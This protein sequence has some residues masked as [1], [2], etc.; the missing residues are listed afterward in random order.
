MTRPN[1]PTEQQLFAKWERDLI[2]PT[3]LDDS[4]YI[5]DPLVD[6]TVEQ[7]KTNQILR[8]IVDSNFGF[9]PYSDI[10][11]R[12]VIEADTYSA[13]GLNM[14]NELHKDELCCQLSDI[15]LFV[16]NNRIEHIIPSNLK[17]H[18]SEIVWAGDIIETI[19][20]LYD[21]ATSEE[22]F[23]DLLKDI[24]LGTASEV[25]KIVKDHFFEKT[26]AI[27]ERAR[28]AKINSTVSQK[29]DTFFEHMNS[30]AV[31][32]L[33]SMSISKNCTYENG[34]EESIELA[35]G[36]VKDGEEYVNSHNYRLTIEKCI[37]NVLSDDLPQHIIN[38]LRAQN[39]NLTFDGTSALLDIRYVRQIEVG[40]ADEASFRDFIEIESGSQYLTIHNDLSMK[41]TLGYPPDGK[42]YD[43]ARQIISS[44]FNVMELSEHEDAM[45]KMDSPLED[46]FID[47]Y[48]MSCE[49]SLPEGIRRMR[50]VEDGVNQLYK[51][52]DID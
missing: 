16:M 30:S 18:N 11:D 20:E 9:W 1:E 38:N 50:V 29:L 45:C 13:V 52:Y 34:V 44:T 27:R 28:I 49:N 33:Y 4:C 26:R 43:D 41:S 24:Y 42:D 22:D 5:P 25:T 14:Y 32:N 3:L 46:V 35:S 15:M 10:E 8:E 40:H 36:L 17:D 12:F 7:S 47:F 31:N 19:T 23:K 48:E 37:K 51:F 6:L 21:T 39:C 2:V